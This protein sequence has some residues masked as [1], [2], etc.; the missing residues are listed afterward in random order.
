[1]FISLILITLLIGG[2][3][4]VWHKD[5]SLIEEFKS[6]IIETIEN[7]TDINIDFK[8]IKEK[9]G[10]NTSKIIIP[11]LKMENE[12]FNIK[13]K[14]VKFGFKTIESIKNKEILITSIKV[15]DLDVLLKEA[16]E[17]SPKKKKKSK[18]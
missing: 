15:K 13:A 2:Y 16:K 17:K 9:W 14:D 12:D 10:L 4:S 11:E 18:E 6:P 1:M 8:E 3:L 5:N 7:T